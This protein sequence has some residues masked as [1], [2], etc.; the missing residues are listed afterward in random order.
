MCV[1]VF[2][3]MVMEISLRFGFSE[4]WFLILLERN[5][6]WNCCGV[7]RFG[8][9][10]FYTEIFRIDE[11]VLGKRV[12]CFVSCVVQVCVLGVSGEFF[13]GRFSV[14][15]LIRVFVW[16]REFRNWGRCFFG[17]RSFFF[18][19]VRILGGGCWMYL[20]KGV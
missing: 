18:T 15:G 16:G 3:R 17:F 20:L 8:L 13:L 2:I 11:L 19:Q 10:C 9:Q 6:C 1:I 14:S 4:V 12:I 7:I 5:L